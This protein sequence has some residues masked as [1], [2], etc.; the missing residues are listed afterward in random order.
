MHSASSFYHGGAYAVQAEM[1]R[2][3]RQVATALPR[4]LSEVFQAAEPL[5]TSTHKHTV[6]YFHS[7]FSLQVKGPSAC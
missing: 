1:L 7:A 4:R 2:W 3:A 6:A 5:R